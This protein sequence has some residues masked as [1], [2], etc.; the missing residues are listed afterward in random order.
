MLD[1]KPEQK[2]TTEL[3]P[4]TPRP[5]VTVNPQVEG[6]AS[7]VAS[8]LNRSNTGT[9]AAAKRPQTILSKYTPL[10]KPDAAPA[11]KPLRVLS[12]KEET[13]CGAHEYNRRDFG[14]Y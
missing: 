2:K 9:T 6:I 10:K 1:K 12:I 3:K 7:K 14:K 13:P 5:A 4:F 11:P 8:I